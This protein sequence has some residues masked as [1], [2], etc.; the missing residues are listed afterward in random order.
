MN[1][2]EL[3]DYCSGTNHPPANFPYAWTAFV[4]MMRGRQY[5]CEPARDAWLWF[6]TGWN[7]RRDRPR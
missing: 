3:R 6:L 2:N 4:L 1:E 5:G 7:A